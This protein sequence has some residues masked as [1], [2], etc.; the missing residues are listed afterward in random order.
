MTIKLNNN[1]EKENVLK[2]NKSLSKLLWLR[3]IFSEPIA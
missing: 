3:Q 2:E 1:L